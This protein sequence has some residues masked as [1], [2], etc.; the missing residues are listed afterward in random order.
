MVHDTSNGCGSYYL[1]SE[2]LLKSGRVCSSSRK[3]GSTN[4]HRASPRLVHNSSIMSDQVL[5]PVD[6]KPH[7]AKPIEK[8]S[9]VWQCSPSSDLKPDK[10]HLHRISFCPMLNQTCVEKHSA[11]SHLLP[12]A[13]KNSDDQFASWDSTWA[14]QN[15]LL[16][17]M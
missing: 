11:R 14:P 17:F 1:R 6:L 8:A 3:V 4:S 7:N 5:Q 13:T 12:M 2:I 9:L 10:K 16:I 15:L